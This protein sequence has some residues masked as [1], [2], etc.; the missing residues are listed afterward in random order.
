MLKMTESKRKETKK[1]FLEVQRKKGKE[2]NTMTK[3]K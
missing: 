2:S 3:E 1:V